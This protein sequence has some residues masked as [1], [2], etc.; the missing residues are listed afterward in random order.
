MNAASCFSLPHLRRCA[1]AA[2]LVFLLAGTA[3]ARAQEAA[4]P[5]VTRGPY[6]QM[7][8]PG[9]LVIRW[10]TDLPCSSR[11]RFGKAADDL[12]RT[13]QSTRPTTEHSIRLLRLAPATQYFYSVGTR[14]LPL[15]AAADQ[16]FFTPPPSGTAEPT[17][18]WVL[19]DA[20]S[21]TPGQR[22]VRD[23]YAE[24][25]G[26]RRTDLWLMLGD[27]AYETGAD[28]EYQKNV[29]EV[30]ATTFRQSPLWP[31]IGNHDTAQSVN[32]PLSIPY[33]QSFTLPTRGQ[34]GGR[35]SGTE[36][37]YSFNHANV[38]FICLDSQTSDRDPLARMARWLRADL[39]A[40]RRLW[41][42]AYWHHPPYSKGSHDSDTEPFSDLMRR[43]IVPLLEAGGTDLVLTGHSHVYERSVLID[44]HY[45]AS[46]TFTAGMEKNGGDG[47]EGSDG[48]YTKPAAKTPH[49][50][51]VYV[52]SGSAGKLSGSWVGGSTAEV[53]PNPHPAMNTS[54]RAMGSV[55]LD[56]D[57]PRL[58]ARFVRD[59]GVVGDSF[60]IL[61]GAQ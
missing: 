31:A 61:K 48:A 45:G 21:G 26:T 60:T 3:P 19:G 57:G 4:P 27:N 6:L 30:Y 37:Y 18:V 9:S 34:A 22:E 15:S 54:L 24:F 17:R 14:A 36:K 49:A 43:N 50:G 56:F 29:F 35:P 11:V 53:N 13:A 51:T 47:R 25:T 55:V 7:A 39:A 16:T 52:V 2:A 10:R 40:N 5:V 20:G 32:P 8:T 33:F 38:H 44:G 58:D 23:A 46:T 59:T 41:T 42:V 28:A 1:M 12:D